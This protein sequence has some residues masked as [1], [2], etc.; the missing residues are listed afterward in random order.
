MTQINIH[1]VY[2]VSN[3]AAGMLGAIIRTILVIS[4]LY[5]IA[6]APLLPASMTAPVNI[7][8]EDIETTTS[9]TNSLPSTKCMKHSFTSFDD[10]R[11]ADVDKCQYRIITL[12]NQLQVLVIHEAG[13]D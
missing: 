1:F 4:C 5:R 6:R 3:C 12:S 9:T 13:L 11:K 8:A 10:I 2:K 7:G